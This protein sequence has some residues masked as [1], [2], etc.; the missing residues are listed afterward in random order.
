MTIHTLKDYVVVT[1]NEKKTETVRESG[2]ILAGD[3]G[4]K[5]EST[6][7][8]VVSVGPDVKFLRPGHVILAQWQKS[9]EVTLS[10]EKNFIIREEDVIAILA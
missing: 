8:T 3:S 5:M 2:I 9:M 4:V 10:G 1:E 7:A 6:T